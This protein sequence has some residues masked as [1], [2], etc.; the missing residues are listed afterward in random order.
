MGTTILDAIDSEMI[1]TENRCRIME[2]LTSARMLGL[3]GGNR[4]LNPQ[5]LN[6]RISINS[7][8]IRL[9]I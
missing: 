8:R 3:I 4:T 6:V 5:Q 1:F 7:A 2:F 9:A